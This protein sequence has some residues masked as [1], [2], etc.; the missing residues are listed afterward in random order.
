MAFDLPELWLAELETGVIVRMTGRGAETPKCICAGSQTQKS[1]SHFCQGT[2]R[3]IS[4]PGVSRERGSRVL[5]IPL[6]ARVGEQ[7]HQLGAPGWRNLSPVPSYNL[8]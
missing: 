5:S 8:Q 2:G 1:H 3:D 7:K 6:G 4:P